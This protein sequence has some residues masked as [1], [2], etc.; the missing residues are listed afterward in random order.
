MYVLAFNNTTVDVAN[1]PINNTN[2]TVVKDRH[3]KF[4]YPTVDITDYNVLID[5][6]NFYDH[7]IGDQIKKY[8]KIIKLA[9][10]KETR[11]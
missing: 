9:T 3:R 4:S 10:D 5:G 7:S 11:F 8:D 6:R 1:N 2:N